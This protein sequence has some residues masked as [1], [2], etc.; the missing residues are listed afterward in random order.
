MHMRKTTREAQF[1]KLVPASVSSN[2]NWMTVPTN[3][4]CQQNL[5]KTINQIFHFNKII[6]FYWNIWQKP[7][8]QRELHDFL[9]TF[10]E[11]R[12]D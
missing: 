11:S 6:F 3:Q 9:E 1:G 4:K 2:E 12:L 5:Q 8:G 10:D 7:D